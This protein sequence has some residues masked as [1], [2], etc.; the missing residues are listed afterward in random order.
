[1]RILIRPIFENGTAG[2][3]SL[4]FPEGAVLAC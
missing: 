1:L 2:L 4:S 3:A